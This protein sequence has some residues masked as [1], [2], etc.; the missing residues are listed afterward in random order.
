V[1]HQLR[2]LHQGKHGSPPPLELT[3]QIVHVSPPLAYW[4]AW[5]YSLV[6]VLQKS[7]SEV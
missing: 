5:G 1:L 7:T 4:V 2:K 6:K 3:L